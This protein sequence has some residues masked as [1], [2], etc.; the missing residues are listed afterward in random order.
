MNNWIGIQQKIGIDHIRVYVEDLENVMVEYLSTK[1][2]NYL[3]LV[4]NS[5]NYSTICGGFQ[6]MVA[7][8]PTSSLQLKLLQICNSAYK[9]VFLKNIFNTQ[10]ND[11]IIM[12]DCL[13]NFKYTYEF[14]TNYNADEVIFPRF[15][16]IDQHHVE[17]NSLL[18]STSCNQDIRT[19]NQSYNIYNYLMK[20]FSE[21]NKTNT[22]CLRFTNVEFFAQ[23]ESLGSFLNKVEDSVSKA[24][25]GTLTWDIDNQGEI[26]INFSLTDFDFLAANDI[27][28]FHKKLSCFQRHLAIDLPHGSGKLIINTRLT[29]AIHSDKFCMAYSS[30][31]DVRQVNTNKGFVSRFQKKTFE[32]LNDISD[33][34]PFSRIISDTE[35]SI[36]INNL[37]LQEL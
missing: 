32:L 34:Y 33:I 3:T 10:I 14:I 27:L 11:L 31:F 1:Y 17:Y 6:I 36:F 8:Y 16:E 35:F 19:Y 4:Q 21:Y 24:K 7:K 13:L 22:A 5:K 20:L 37:A 18:Q 25:T 26:K 23:S 9:T 28:E 29:E 15:Y 12:N 2:R 30:N